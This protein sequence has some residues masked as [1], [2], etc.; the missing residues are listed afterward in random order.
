MTYNRTRSIREWLADF[1]KETGETI[2]HLCVGFDDGPDSGW[3]AGY[4]PEEWPRFAANRAMPVADFGD[5]LDV[6]FNPDSQS[7]VKVCGWSPSW[8]L[9]TA[10]YD[11]S[12]WP[13]WVPRNPTDH[14]PLQAG[15]G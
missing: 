1:T 2:T 14:R 15:G 13:T 9:L 6:R 11:G 12:I 10:L 3:R 7:W 4:W 8:V 5:V